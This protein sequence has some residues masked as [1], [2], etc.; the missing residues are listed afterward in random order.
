LE[1]RFQDCQRR[2]PPH[3]DWTPPERCAALPDGVTVP[4]PDTLFD[5]YANRAS[6]LKS[7]KLT[8]AKD[9]SLPGDLKIWPAKSVG[10]IPEMYRARNEE[11]RKLNPQ[12]ADLIHWKYQTYVKDCLRC[13]KSVDDSVG[14]VMDYLEKHNLADNTAVIYSSD[15]SFYLGEHGWLDKHWISEESIH[16]PFIIRWPGAVK[17]GSRPD[18]MI[19]NIDY[20]PT[21][22]EIAGGEVPSGLHGHSFPSCT[23]RR[24]RTGAQAFITATTTMDGA[25]PGTTACGSRTAC[26]CIILKRMNGICS[27]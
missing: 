15:Q 1:L 4:E 7:Q 22:V 9:M 2:K 13:V 12:G 18:A 24:R 10:Q 14:R 25:W 11:F 3:R 16:M 26:R 17:P 19:Q 8:V 6:P 5:D 27:T 20:A 21:L 23:G